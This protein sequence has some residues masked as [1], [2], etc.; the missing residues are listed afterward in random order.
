MRIN[1]NTLRYK[2]RMVPGLKDVK[3][4]IYRR[5]HRDMVIK[6]REVSYVYH[7]ERMRDEQ[8]SESGANSSVVVT[9]HMYE[10]ELGDWIVEEN[11]VLHVLSPKHG[12]DV[13]LRVTAVKRDLMGL[14]HVCVCQPDAPVEV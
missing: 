1:R 7:K 10:A 12:L 8:A 11:D 13:W 2:H 4:T 9:V 14:R 6:T 3:A 5:D